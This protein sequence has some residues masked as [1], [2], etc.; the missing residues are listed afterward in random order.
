MASLIQHCIVISSDNFCTVNY[1]CYGAK[2]DK[3]FPQLLSGIKSTKVLKDLHFG[4]HIPASHV[5]MISIARPCVLAM[6]SNRVMT[7]KSLVFYSGSAPLYGKESSACPKLPN[8]G[9]KLRTQSGSGTVD[10]YTTCSPDDMVLAKVTSL[11]EAISG[12]LLSTAANEL[13]VVVAKHA[14]LGEKM[15]SVKI[16]LQN[17]F[18][19][20]GPRCSVR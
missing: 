11:G 8:F 18:R 3:L 7:S 2:F 12:F 17:L 15:I 4:W 6:G 19:F 9:M 14:D 1:S 5:V 16:Y 20:L 13:G 10:L